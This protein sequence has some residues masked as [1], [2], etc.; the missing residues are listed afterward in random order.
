MSTAG[1]SIELS[2]CNNTA[3]RKASR[4]LS[5]AYD[6]AL[7]PS[8][9]RSTQ[10]SVLAEIE[11]RTEAPLTIRALADVLVMDR[12][13]LGQNLRPLERDG[14]LA[15]SGN[16][17][18]ARSKYVVL[19]DDGKKKVVEAHALWRLAQ[20]QFE[21]KFGAKE[22]AALRTTLLGIANDVSPTLT[23]S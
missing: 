1:N 22:A 16:P 8:G 3:L 19:T 15:F 17:S 14:L 4:R 10:L 2:R 21:Q 11:R 12:S 20:N 18:D 7:A 9:L 6:E 5:R 23:T 13:T